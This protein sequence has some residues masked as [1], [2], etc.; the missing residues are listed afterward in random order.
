MPH[1]DT[2]ND[3]TELVGTLRW[4]EFEG[5]FWSVDL[6]PAESPEPA[7]PYGGRIVLG[8][9]P[10]PAGLVDGAHVRVRGR[11]REDMLDFLMAGTRFDATSI[12]LVEP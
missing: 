11:A 9:E 5:G 1:H 12:E 6:D 8:S 4:N 7:P 2:G 10:V 3:D